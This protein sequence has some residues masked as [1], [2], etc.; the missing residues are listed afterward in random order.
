MKRTILNQNILEIDNKIYNVF[1]LLGIFSFVGILFNTLFLM[2]IPSIFFP[3][4][5]ILLTLIILEL[6]I[7]LNNKII[8]KFYR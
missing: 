3:I 7:F 2:F 6:G 8:N 5:I 4:K 1:L